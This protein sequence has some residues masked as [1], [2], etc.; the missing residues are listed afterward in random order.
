VA[1]VGVMSALD[2]DIS[3]TDNRFENLSLLA[4]EKLSNPIAD[5]TDRSRTCAF[6]GGSSRSA[7]TDHSEDEVEVRTRQFVSRRGFRCKQ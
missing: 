1:L 2:C 4:P 5:P 7:K 6:S 3:M